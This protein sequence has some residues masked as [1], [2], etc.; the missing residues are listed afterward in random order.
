MNS[1]CPDCN[2]SG[3]PHD[4]AIAD[5]CAKC[6]GSG[7]VGG[8]LATPGDVIQIDPTNDPAFGGCYATVET[9]KPWGVSMCFV[10]SPATPGSNFY[11][12][13]PHDAYEVI[14]RAEWVQGDTEGSD[15]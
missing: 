3:Y 4:Q 2:G 10:S 13:V 11:Y 15:Q 9:V 6:S 8:V 7:W 5:I 14:G 1:K 12:R